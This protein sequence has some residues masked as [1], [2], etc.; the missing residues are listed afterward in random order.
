VRANIEA[1]ITYLVA[2][3][4]PAPATKDSKAP[5]IEAKFSDWGLTIYLF[6]T[7]FEKA[8]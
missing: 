1:E 6:A 8:K 3:S 4:N 2:G 7:N 5:F